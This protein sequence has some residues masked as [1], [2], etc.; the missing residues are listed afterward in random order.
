MERLTVPTSSCILRH[1]KRNQ[2]F[3][4]T[5]FT[6][7]HSILIRSYSFW[8]GFTMIFHHFRFILAFYNFSSLSHLIF[9]A[10][11]SS[12]H[13]SHVSHTGPTL[14]KSTYGSEINAPPRAY[15]FTGFR[16]QW[17]VK[18]WLAALMTVSC[19]LAHSRL[20][21][22]DTFHMRGMNGTWKKW[23]NE[24]MRAEAIMTR[25]EIDNQLS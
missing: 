17:C 21:V 18:M 20:R 1:G 25:S 9:E 11:F 12:V 22:P 4:A 8:H 2:F 6:R 24:T 7:R 5:W 16:R 23:H 3:F 13:G 14:I 10:S 15:F 19:T